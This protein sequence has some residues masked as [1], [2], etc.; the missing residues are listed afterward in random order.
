MN[1]AFD[2]GIAH[3]RLFPADTLAQ[4]V[5]AKLEQL[6]GD[7]EPFLYGA[8]HAGAVY[9]TEPPGSHLSNRARPR[10]ISHRTLGVGDGI[11]DRNGRFGARFV[12]AGD[13]AWFAALQEMTVDGP[14]GIA[15]LRELRE[16]LTTDSARDR[17]SIGNKA[18][19]LV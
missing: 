17:S 15:G 1:Q 2:F 11:P 18:C 7:A 10:T 5:L 13:P 12:N 16:V 4:H 8:R 19:R 9:A 14:D 6:E 3:V